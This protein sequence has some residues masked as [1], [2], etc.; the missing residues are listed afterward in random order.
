LVFDN[1]DA[2]NSR[3]YPGTVAWQSTASPPL[4]QTNTEAGLW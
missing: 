1:L 3:R 4:H 2:K